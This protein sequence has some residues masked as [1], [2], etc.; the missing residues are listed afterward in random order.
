VPSR[1]YLPGKTNT[2]AL[3]AIG[4]RKS[5]IA[6]VI[7]PVVRR[8]ERRFPNAKIGMSAGIA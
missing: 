4:N 1:Q 6:I 3:F 5:K 8:I 2:W 7:V